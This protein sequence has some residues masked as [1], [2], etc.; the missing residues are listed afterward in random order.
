MTK[1]SLSRRRFIAGAGIAIGA[2]MT[3]RS[4]AIAAG[5]NS[6]ADPASTAPFRY[7]FNTSTIRGQKL[8]LEKEIEITSQAGYNAIEPWVDKIHAYVS[9]GGNLRDIRN[10]INETVE[11]LKEIS[12]PDTPLEVFGHYLYNPHAIFIGDE[13]IIITPYYI[14]KKRR[15]APLF[16]YKDSSESIYTKS[17][18][19]DIDDLKEDSDKLL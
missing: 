8:S 19:S 6:K 11:L 2:V 18:M 5:D 13:N 7:C 4:R 15:S 10:K 3:N 16:R 9:N 14:S 17:I 1:K 12:N